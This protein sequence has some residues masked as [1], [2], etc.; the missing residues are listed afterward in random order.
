VDQEIGELNTTAPDEPD[1]GYTRQISVFT[2]VGNGKG[3]QTEVRP[4]R[5]GIKIAAFSQKENSDDIGFQTEIVSTADIRFVTFGPQVTRKKYRVSYIDSGRPKG[6]NFLLNPGE[7]RGAFGVLIRTRSDESEEPTINERFSIEYGRLHTAAFNYATSLGVADKSSVS[8]IFSKTNTVGK[9]LDNFATRLKDGAADLTTA[10]LRSEN[11]GWNQKTEPQVV[12]AL[13]TSMASALWA[14]VNEISNV[15]K[16]VKGFDGNYDVFMGHRR[17]FIHEYTDGEVKISDT[18]PAKAFFFAD[19]YKETADW[20]PIF[21]VSD[22]GG[23]EVFGNM[24]YGRGVTI[25]RY[26]EL[27]RSTTSGDQTDSGTEAA[28][29]STT[30][31]GTTGGSNAASLNAIEKFFAAYLITEDASAALGVV[32]DAEKSA[33]LATL[34]TTEENIESAVQT[35]TNQD[36]SQNA[37]IRNSPVTSFFRG[38]SVFGDTAARNLANL[39]VGG[40]ICVCK[41]VEASFLLQA[42]SEEFVDLFDDPAQAFAESSAFN[43]SEAWK[44]AKDAMSGR[45]R[46]VGNDGLAQEFEAQGN[47]SRTFGSLSQSIEDGN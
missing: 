29:S 1:E 43:S 21:P 35:L 12:G 40:E 18:D 25:E 9:A 47:A 44:E 16:R 19:E 15:A 20:T 14:Y 10:E 13:A 45:V 37:K 8:K 38:Q 23:Y 46:D 24:P 3:I 22:A 2:D 36:T 30:L 5:R 39:D 4:I 11:R 26:A 27:I 17:D 31:V 41:G 42:F 32:S 6:W 7:T 28:E 34:N 33:V